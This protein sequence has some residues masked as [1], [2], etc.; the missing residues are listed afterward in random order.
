MSKNIKHWLAL[1]AALA[2][3]VV[4]AAQPANAAASK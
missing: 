2:M 3:L 1:F 4:S